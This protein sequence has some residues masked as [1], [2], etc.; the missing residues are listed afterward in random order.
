M[1]FICRQTYMFLMACLS[2]LLSGFIFDVF[3]VKRKLVRTPDFLVNIEDILYWL[4]ISI[5]LFSLMYYSN[6]GELRSYILLGLIIGVII[7]I[8]IFSRYV[9]IILVKTITII[10]KIIMFPVNIVLK[11]FRVPLKI[12]L[13]NLN[14]VK[15]VCYNLWNIIT[16]KLKFSKKTVQKILEK[17]NINVKK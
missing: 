17:C 4:I 14:R 15:G 1:D 2:G 5:V 11:I 13:K 10:I 16:R 8:C 3:R 12:I 7:Y 9:F 6:E